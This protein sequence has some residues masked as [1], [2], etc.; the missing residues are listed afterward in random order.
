MCHVTK[1]IA[2]GTLTESLCHVMEREQQKDPKLLAGQGSRI[3]LVHSTTRMFPTIAET[4]LS[5]YQ[6]SFFFCPGHTAKLHFLACPA[7]SWKNGTDF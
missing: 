6:N 3:S 2:L 5:G 7:V 4:M 1:Q